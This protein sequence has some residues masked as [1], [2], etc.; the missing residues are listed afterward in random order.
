MIEVTVSNNDRDH[1]R[2]MVNPGEVSE[3]GYVA[4]WFDLETV[5]LIAQRTQEDALDCGHGS[6]DTVHVVDGGTEQGKPRVLVVVITWMDIQSK[7][8]GEATQIVEPD[9]EGRYPIGG[10]P[11]CWYAVD[12]DLNPLIPFRAEQ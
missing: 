12:A 3:D 5:R 7:G 6:I 9:E 8:V 2:A 1:Y 4:P 10:F 11:W